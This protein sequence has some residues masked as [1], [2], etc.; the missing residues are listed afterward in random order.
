M[1]LRKDYYKILGIDKTASTQDIKKAY[2]KLAREY[3]PDSKSQTAD[4]DKFRDITEAYDILTD[5]DKRIRYDQGQMDASWFTDQGLNNIKDIFEK[6]YRKATKEQPKKEPTQ[7]N[8]T[9]SKNRFSFSD[10]FNSFVDS[11][12]SRKETKEQAAPG[13]NA[14][15]KDIHQ[16]I[17]ITLEEAYTGTR[18]KLSIPKENTCVLCGGKGEIGTQSCRNCYGEGQVRK[19]KQ[20]E[21][22]IPAG[23]RQGS[24]VRI[25]GEGNGVGELV[26]HL[27]LHIIIQEH[28]FFTIKENGDLSCVVPITVAEAVLGA[29]IEVPTLGGAVK[30]KIPPGTPNHKVFRLRGKG[31]KNRKTEEIGDQYLTVEVEIPTTLSLREAE[32]YGELMRLQRNVRAHLLSVSP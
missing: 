30:M 16:D 22:N 2:R 24:K 10:M 8:Q 13:I 7:D 20:L 9:K 12:S 31:L 19:H 3:H 14:V 26:G 4:K 29:E 23:V 21:V 25:P 5:P 11:V 32:L 27:F 15:A 1:I 6:T 18:K 28:R 17:T